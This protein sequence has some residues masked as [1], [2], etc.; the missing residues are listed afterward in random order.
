MS[1]F[2]HDC[3]ILL[4][5]NGKRSECDGKVIWLIKIPRKREKQ[6]RRFGFWPLRLC[7]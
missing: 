2:I 3:Q 7:Q 6:F 5:F 4:L 1:L